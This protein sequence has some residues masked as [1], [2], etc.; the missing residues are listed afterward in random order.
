[1]VHATRSASVPPLAWLLGSLMLGLGA[2]PCQAGSP[3]LESIKQ[4]PQQART[5]CTALRQLNSQGHPALS[6]EGIA[7]VASR[8]GLSPLDAEIVTTYVV[9]L[10]CPD[11]R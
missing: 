6:T 2:A 5:L 3:L 11:V 7:L 9:G 1:M 10:Y 4:N 8:Q